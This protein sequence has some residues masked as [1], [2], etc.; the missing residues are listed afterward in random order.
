M[1]VCVIYVYIQINPSGTWCRHFGYTH[2]QASSTGAWAGFS[3]SLPLILTLTCYGGPSFLHI[4]PC[5]NGPDQLKVFHSRHF[6]W[7]HFF[8]FL[9]RI[10]S[11][12]FPSPQF[13]AE[14]K[15]TLDNSQHSQT[16]VVFDTPSS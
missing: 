7:Q 1:C 8:F 9:R 12:C 11:Q 14:S 2:R 15:E 16:R 5:K 3:S 13:P 10:C 4:G 6:F